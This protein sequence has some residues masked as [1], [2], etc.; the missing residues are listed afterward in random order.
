M[1]GEDTIEVGAIGVM[2]AD[3]GNVRQVTQRVRPTHSEDGEPVWSPDGKR[4]AFVRLNVTAK[5]RDRKAI[6]VVN[7]DGS[8]LKRLTPVVAQRQGPPRL[9]AGRARDP[10]PVGARTASTSRAIST[11]CI[12]TAR[13][14]GS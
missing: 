11:R 12:P 2:D 13:D 1:L 10:V 3:G 14:C 4:I 5:P 6:F 7:A 8:G 9:V